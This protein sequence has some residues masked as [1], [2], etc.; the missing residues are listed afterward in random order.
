[1][2][3]V[4]WQRPWRR[5]ISTGG[6][7]NIFG[8]GSDGDVT[9][10]TSATLSRDMYY[11]NLTITSAGSLNPSGYRIFVAGTLTMAPGAEIQRYGSNGDDSGIPGSAQATG[12]MAGG[13][14]GGEGAWGSITF[15]TGGVAGTNNNTALGGSGGG[16]GDGLN[17][18]SA[19]GGTASHTATLGGVEFGASYPLIIR[20]TTIVLNTRLG[21]GCGGGGGGGGDGVTSPYVGGG[22]GSGAGIILISARKILAASGSLIN[23]YGGDGGNGEGDNCGGGGG[24]GGGAFVCFTSSSSMDLLWTINVSGG[25]AGLGGISLGGTAG[26]DGAPGSDGNYYIVTGDD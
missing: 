16:G 23:L 21:G 4:S 13:T 5:F 1:M 9:I 20:G 25:A 17:T 10:S 8:D 12:T 2:A 6:F 14:A 26:D 19:S 18:S 24:G 11:E 7:S 3:G 15:P 22:G